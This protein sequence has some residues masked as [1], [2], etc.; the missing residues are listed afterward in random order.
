MFFQVKIRI[1]KNRAELKTASSGFQF[2]SGYSENK[3]S[4]VAPENK[5]KRDVASPAVNK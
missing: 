2:L 3:S 1:S 4:A 5:M